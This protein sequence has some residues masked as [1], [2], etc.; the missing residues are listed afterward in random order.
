MTET[1]SP[2]ALRARLRSPG[3]FGAYASALE[4]ERYV[5]QLPGRLRNR[6]RCDCGCGGKTSHAGMANGL[7]LTDGCELS[8]RRWARDGY[9]SGAG[10]RRG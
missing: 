8:M 7:A 6:R 1:M 9:R 3:G 2:A 5:Q 10:V 4:H